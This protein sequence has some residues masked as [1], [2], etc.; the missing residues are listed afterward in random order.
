MKTVDLK[1]EIVS[2]INT[3]AEKLSFAVQPDEN[4]FELIV[5]ALVRN[6]N[7]HGEYY[8]PCKLKRTQENICPCGRMEDE[9]RESGKCHCGLFIRDAK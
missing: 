5:N 8:C 1:S 4:R 9:V 2:I 7:L 6:K 3:R